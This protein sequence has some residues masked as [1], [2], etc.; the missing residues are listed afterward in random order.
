MLKNSLLSLVVAFACASSLFEPQEAFS[1]ALPSETAPAIA[2]KVLHAEGLLHGFLVLKNLDGAVLADG[3]LTQSAQGDRVK[4]RLV[5]HF[6]DT[7][8]YE[9]NVI[10][11][12]RR[13]FRLL[14]YRL[15][16]KGPAFKLPMEFSLD[17]ATGLATVHYTD[18]EGKQKIE[19]ERM[20]IQPDLANGMLTTLLK[21]IPPDAAETTLSLVAATPKPR[22]VKLLISEEGED[23][24][25]VGSSTHKAMR[26][27]IKFEITGVAG[28]VVP[29]VGK[30]P[31][32]LRIWVL[33]GDAPTFLKSEGPLYSGGPVWR[34]ELTSPVWQNR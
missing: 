25:S 31:P 17:G 24:F 22:L 7:S 18:S 21:D 9:E 20:K 15:T 27:R 23:W 34:I 1:R 11:S 33:N 32:D 2:P 29:L 10:F 26:Y 28:V 13:V 16:Q 4:I 30:Q 5:F 3:E 14:S 6:K 8:V 12:Q 19:N